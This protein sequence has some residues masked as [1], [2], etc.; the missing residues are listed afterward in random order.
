MW[1][2]M[3]SREKLA[4]ASHVAADD[5]ADDPKDGE[6]RGEKCADNCASGENVLHGLWWLMSVLYHH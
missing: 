2:L 1:W 4:I 3:W 5:A 6:L